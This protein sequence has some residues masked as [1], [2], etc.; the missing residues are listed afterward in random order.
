MDLTNAVL[1]HERNAHIEFHEKKHE[2]Y[3]KGDKHPQ[4]FY[5][6]TSL[7]K[8][9]Q[10]PFDAEGI[11]K[12][13]AKRDGKTQQQVLDEW[14]A[15]GQKSIELGNYIHKNIEDYVNDGVEG[16]EWIINV[17]NEAIEEL[18]IEPI[19]C[20]WVVYDDEIGRASAIDGVYKWKDK[21]ELVIVDY[22]TNEDWETK[23]WQTY[24]QFHYPIQHLPDNKYHK[25]SLQL[26]VYKNWVR[27]IYQLP[28][29]DQMFILHI[30]DG[31]YSW[32]PVLDFQK[33]VEM[34]YKNELKIAA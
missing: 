24:N 22:K 21:D 15:K 7:L 26:N 28:V 23:Y 18:G 6:V 11:S 12:Y 10:E 14:N 33:E 17:H 32:I 20:E 25:Y 34:I 2:Y 30:R 1:E 19:L 27:N 8:E 5:G 29:S 3:W 4:Q 16:E 31:E 9:Y 13:V